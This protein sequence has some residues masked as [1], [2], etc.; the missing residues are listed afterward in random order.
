MVR[1][2]PA[3]IAAAAFAAGLIAV[4]QAYAP[5]PPFLVLRHLMSAANCATASAMRLAPA[6]RGE[7]GYWPGL[8]ADND[9]IACEW[10]SR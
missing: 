5:W 10:W 2:L 9:G 1:R 3:L 7:P 6:R 8:D 4:L